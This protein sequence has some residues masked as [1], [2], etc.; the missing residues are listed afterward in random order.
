MIT[1]LLKRSVPG[2]ILATLLFATMLQANGPDS[3]SKSF[4][5]SKGGKFVLSTS[6]GDVTLKPWDKDEVFV[7]VDGIDPDDVDKLE[8]SQSGNTVTVRFRRSRSS[9]SDLRYEINLPSEFN[10]DLKTAGGDIEFTGAM[11]GMLEGETAG[12][13]IRL[14][15]VKGR[16]VFTTAGGDIRTGKIGGDAK[17]KT[18]GGDIEV[19]EAAGEVQAATAGG[20][21]KVGN[22]G[23]SLEAKTSGGDINVGDVGGEA[24]VATSGGDISLG[25]V[26]GKARAST[27]GGDIEIRSA[28][29][30][31]AAKTAG[32]DIKL[33]DITGSVEA[34]TAGGD[35]RAELNPTGRGSSQLKTAGGEIVLEIPSTA[36]ATIEALIELDERWAKRDK[37][38]VRSD[39]KADSYE[40][41]DD[42]IRA[43]YT[44]NGGGETIYLETVNSNI[45]IRKSR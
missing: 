35:V 15:D 27:A 24:E 26:S 29:G 1:T 20:D 7:R 2:V 19:R 34:K 30:S 25:K 22:V 38:E 14:S 12:G 9:W 4:P 21:I 18:A 5:V 23:K 32:G 11:V 3:R 42:Y 43:K 45:T 8:M 28:S 33:S 13:D 41:E 17:L 31:V 6:S 40:K 39:F 44:L 10:V 37:Y 16:I 36:K